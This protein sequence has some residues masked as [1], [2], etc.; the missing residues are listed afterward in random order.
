MIFKSF[1]VSIVSVIIFLCALGLLTYFISPKEFE[2]G[3]FVQFLFYGSGTLI[4]LVF[5]I[6]L[7]INLVVNGRIKSSRCKSPETIY[8]FCCSIFTVIPILAFVLFDYSDRGRYF[9]EKTFLSIVG[10]YA[11]Y[12]LLAVFVIFLNRKI[13]WNNF[14]AYKPGAATR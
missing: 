4:P 9:E 7:L 5:G 6:V 13:S 1:F 3:E 14:K 8:F 12:F 11:V 10:E 2:A